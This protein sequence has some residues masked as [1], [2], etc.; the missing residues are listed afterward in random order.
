[1]TN[2]KPVEP[3]ANARIFVVDSHA[4]IRKQL[5]VWI[6]RQPELSFCGEADNEHAA[7]SAIQEAAPDLVLMDLTFNDA[8]GLATLAEIRRRHP[9]L[10]VLALSIHDSLHCQ[11]KA[12]RAGAHGYITKQAAVNYL[13][14]AIRA[15]LDGGTYFQTEAGREPVAGAD[16]W[17]LKT[18]PAGGT[19]R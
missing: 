12:L 2:A 9:G 6:A 16:S 17:K 5:A 19:S 1:M 15:V 8:T 4:Q 10:P 7:L 11:R 3:V 13:L 14:T 18:N